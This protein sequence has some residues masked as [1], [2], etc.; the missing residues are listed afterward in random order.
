[1]KS[2]P[3]SVIVLILSNLFPLY[4]VLFLNWQVSELMALYWCENVILGIFNIPKII[5]ARGKGKVEINIP[6]T[7]LNLVTN[8]L[9]KLFIIPFFLIHYGGFCLGQGFFIYL[10]FF[11]NI[12]F[13]GSTPVLKI[14]QILFLFKD[15]E[16]AII[17]MF[18]SHGFSFFSNFIMNKEYEIINANEQMMRPYSRIFVLHLTILFGAMLSVFLKNNLGSLMVMIIAKIWVDIQAHLKAHEKIEKINIQV[19]V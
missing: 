13:I 15:L 18:L 2:L 11:Q 10:I 6:G 12:I 9:N 16:P 19:N 4:G 8:I 14:Q 17:F 7:Q 5:L 3:I 1:M